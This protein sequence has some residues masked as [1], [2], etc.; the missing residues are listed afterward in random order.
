MG[1]TNEILI[2]TIICGSCKEPIPDHEK[3][4]AL[5]SS[6]SQSDLEDVE[7]ISCENKYRDSSDIDN[8]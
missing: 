7:C 1:F 4:V 5:L 6:L 3:D 8:L 2:A